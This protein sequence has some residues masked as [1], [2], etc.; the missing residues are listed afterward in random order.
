LGETNPTYS[1]ICTLETKI[2]WFSESN[3]TNQFY[4]QV[5]VLDNSHNFTMIIISTMLYYM[6]LLKAVRSNCKHF[7]FGPE[8]TELDS[9]TRIFMRLWNVKNVVSAVLSTLI[10]L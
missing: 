7:F 8:K 6:I 5:C 2:C 1:T 4:I 10:Q 9:D 3:V